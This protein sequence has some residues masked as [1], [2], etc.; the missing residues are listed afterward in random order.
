M[1][2]PQTNAIKRLRE[3]FRKNNLTIYVG[4]GASA[5]SGVPT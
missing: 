2:G 1:R 4:A 5:A 3:A